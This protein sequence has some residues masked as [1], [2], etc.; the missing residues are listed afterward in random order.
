MTPVFKNS[1]L[2]GQELFKINQL[3]SWS[4]IS[5]TTENLP[6]ET[7][8]NKFF[9]VSFYHQKCKIL[10]PIR[11]LNALFN[12]PGPN[13]FV[14]VSSLF[15]MDRLLQTIK[16]EKKELFLKIRRKKCHKKKNNFPSFLELPISGQSSLFLSSCL[17]FNCT[18]LH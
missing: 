1:L 4:W 3:S 8:L 12:R 18:C 5:I 15:S 10:P 9:V 2:E 7:I 13:D 17:S 11:I 16:N 14:L 6:V